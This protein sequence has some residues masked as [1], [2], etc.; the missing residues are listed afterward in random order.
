[1]EGGVV[2]GVSDGRIELGGGLEWVE[3]VLR[4]VI[5]MVSNARGGA[6]AR[7]VPRLCCGAVRWVH[8]CI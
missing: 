4:S 6:R 1:M 7:A 3:T 8:V 5:A 2:E